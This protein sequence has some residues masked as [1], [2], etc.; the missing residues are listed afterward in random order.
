MAISIIL[1]RNKSDPTVLNKDL[2]F[3]RSFTGTFREP[4]DIVAP[5]LLL[6]Y[7][8]PPDFNYIEIRSL[9][10]F[11]FVNNYTNISTNL[12]S[13]ELSVDVLESYKKTVLGLTAIVERNEHSFNRKLVDTMQVYEA[14]HNIKHYYGHHEFGDLM[15]NDSPRFILNAPFFTVEGGI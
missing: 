12:W 14:G 10:R 9:K 15:D 1:Y 4:F 8:S 6:E 2:E 3:V 5:V 13:L 7:D 11:Y